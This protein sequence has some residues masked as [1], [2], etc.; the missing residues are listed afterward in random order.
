MNKIAAALVLCIVGSTAGAEGP[1]AVER[2]NWPQWRGPTGTG[3]AVN[4]SPPVEWSETKNV[5]WK[6]EI[7]GSG[8]A[9]PIVWGDRVYVQTAIKTDK[10]VKPDPN[11]QPEAPAEPEAGRERRGRRGQGRDADR[12]RRDRGDGDGTRGGGPRDEL[13]DG[14]DRQDRGD[15]TGRGRGR[16]DRQGRGNQPRR[17]R[18]GG[19]RGRAKPTHIYKFSM[20]AL[21]RQTGKVIWQRDVIEELPHEAGHQTNT[22]APASPVTDGKHLYA[23]FGSR[24]LFCLD[25]DGKIVWKKDLGD[26]RTRNGFGEGSS[27]TL[28]GDSLIVN[29]DHEGDSFI[30]VFDKKTGKERWRVARDEGTTWSTPI[31]VE[32]G[33]KPQVIT[34]ANKF[35]RAYDLAT[36]KELWKCGGVGGNAIASPIAVDGLVFVMSGGRR[37]SLRAVKAADAKGEIADDAG[38]AWKQEGGGRGGIGSPLL[39]EGSIYVLGRSGLSC[40][41]AKTGK[42]RYEPQRLEGF[43]TGY[44]SPVGAGGRIYLPGGNGSTVVLEHGKAFKILATN[45]LDDSFDASPAVVGKELYLRGHKYLYCIAPTVK[46]L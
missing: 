34:T 39:Y 21:D 6:V 11:A 46:E 10:E 25:M 43:K 8:H 36:G 19:R 17:G 27:P 12:G 44:A 3:A 20:L 13:Q 35:N 16:G 45:A 38:F 37:A 24:G 40:L 18:R 32:A 7:P 15:R 33:G 31:V 5:R 41:D 2:E 14:G 23:Y 9:T 22:L 29:W 26:M 42:A 4:A 1:S 28:Y 30:V